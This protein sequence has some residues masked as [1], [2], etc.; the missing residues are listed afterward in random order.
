MKLA[1]FGYL[2]RAERAVI[3]GL[4][5]G[6]VTVMGDGELPGE[7]AGD[8]RQ[9]RATLIRWLALGAPGDER[10]HL[11]EKGLRIAGALVVSDGQVDPARRP[12]GVLPRS[13]P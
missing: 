13:G 2:T 12:V 1:D 5:T 8:D 9:V 11:H 4:G 3:A 6:H 7:D 10:V